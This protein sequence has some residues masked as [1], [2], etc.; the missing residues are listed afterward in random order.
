MTTTRSEVSHT[1]DA[2]QA[3]GLGSGRLPG[4]T[5][6]DLNPT[7]RAFYDSMVA[8][9]VP[10]A[11]SGGAKAI[12]ADG[13]LLGPF[14]P[15]LFSP[16]ISSAM[17]GVFRADKANTSL[18]ARAHEIVILTVGA[19]CNADYELYAHRAIAAAVGLPPAMITA[20]V[21]GGRPSFDADADADAYDLTWQLTHTNRVD[22]RT[23]R[24]ALH[25]F[26]A[27]GLVDMVMLIGLY[28][29]VGAIVNLF[30]VPVPEP[31]FGG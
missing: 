8:N 18:P 22:E 25:T 16:A 12:A 11:E 17:L 30:E 23:Y 19:A 9:E 24:R 7:Q 21:A 6:S 13:S 15:L 1:L 10:W 3:P 28:L 31:A 26:G 20:I 27:A 29:T 4:L 14:N 5:R 2:T